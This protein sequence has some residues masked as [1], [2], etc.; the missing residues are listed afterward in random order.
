MQRIF[1]I[2]L[3]STTLVAGVVAAI[4]WWRSSRQD[5][6]LLPEPEA[7]ISDSPEQHIQIAV[8]NLNTVQASL[9]KV[10]NLNSTA[11]AWSGVAALLGAITTA[12]GVL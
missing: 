3:A 12:A 7:S 5:A 1:V 4:Y 10:S 8:V 2:V 6:V 9:I 11:A